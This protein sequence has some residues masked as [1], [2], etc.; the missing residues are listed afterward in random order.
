MVLVQKTTRPS[1]KTNTNTPETII[2]I[3]TEGTCPNVFY[4]T[5][6]TLISKPHRLNKERE[7]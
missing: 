4:E 6:V 7:I 2:K 5:T 3:E 1:M